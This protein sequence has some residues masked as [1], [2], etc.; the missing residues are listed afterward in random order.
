MIPGWLTGALHDERM[1]VYEWARQENPERWRKQA[2]Q[3][4][5]VGVVHLNPE[6][7]QSAK[8]LGHKQKIAQLIT[9]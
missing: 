2:R 6:T 1:L 8:K 7:E 9:L 3:W 5:H 4:A